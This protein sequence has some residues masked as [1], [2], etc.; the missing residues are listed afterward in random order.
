MNQAPIVAVFGLSGVGKSWL[1]G[2]YA[3]HSPVLHVQASQLLREAKA[4]IFGENVTSEE[5]RKGAV[6][7]NQALLIHAFARV[8][9]TATQPIV[10]DG[11]SVVDNGAQLL[12]IPT[13]VVAALAVSHLVFVEDRAKD[14]L[15]RRQNDT[16]RVRPVRSEAELAYHQQRA[17]AVC[18][19]YS[20]NLNLPLTIV[21]AG[22]EETFTDALTRAFAN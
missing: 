16:M 15:E 7:D 5:L 22:D 11:H 8:R 14:I 13:E 21:M 17:K 10:F 4:A 19:V 12:E 3:K 1:I 18:E 6:L 2:R 9:E 20:K